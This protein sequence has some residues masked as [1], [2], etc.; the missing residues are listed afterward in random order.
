MVLDKRDVTS[1]EGMFQ[2][3][4]EHMKYSFNGGII[5][6]AI[7]IFRKREEGKGDMR[8]WNALML[9]FAGYGDASEQGT[10]NTAD[11]GTQGDQLNAEFTQV[12]R[13]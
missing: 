5:R 11:G 8:V 13:K 6:P 7:T 10:D 9:M 2:A 1:T 4:A 12:S 3:L